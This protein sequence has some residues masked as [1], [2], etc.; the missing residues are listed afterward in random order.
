M[1]IKRPYYALHQIIKGQYTS[2]NEYVYADGSGYIGTYHILPTT[3]IFTDPIPKVDSKQLF[4][5]RNDIPEV[6]KR[7]NFI[8]GQDASRYVSPVSYQPLVTSDDYEFGTIQRFFV[9]KRNNPRATITEIDAVQ[10]NTINTSNVPGINGV[11]WNSLL[12]SWVI[13][14]I[15]MDDAGV[16]N[17]RTLIT[18]EQNFEWIGIYVPNILEFYK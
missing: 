2:G 3:Q 7:Y 11:I 17:R 5:R 9:Q 1:P 10:F 14:K 15:P 4:E 18:A 13:S 6:V 12:I 16:I 8:T